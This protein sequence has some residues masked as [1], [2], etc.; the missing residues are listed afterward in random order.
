[1]DRKLLENY[2][3]K[4]TVRIFLVP[5]GQNGINILR[6]QKWW[7]PSI[8]DQI[9]ADSPSFIVK[10]S[11]ALHILFVSSIYSIKGFGKD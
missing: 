1:M 9:K 7:Y 6:L 11:N 3:N 4:N 2:D 5:R 10:T 8:A